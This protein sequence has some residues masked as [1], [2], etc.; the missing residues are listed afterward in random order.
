MKFH[1]NTNKADGRICETKNKGGGTIQRI[2][3]IVLFFIFI[4]TLA[5]SIEV[6]RKFRDKGYTPLMWA[7]F[8]GDIDEVRSIIDGGADL[9]AKNSKGMTALDIA[10]FNRHEEIIK[11]LLKSGGG[12]RSSDGRYIDHGD[13]TITDTNT[14]L[15]WTKEDSYADLGKCLDWNN[16]RRYVNQL[17]T[18][19]YSDWRIP[20]VNEFKAIYE[21]SKKH[22]MG[23]EHKDWRSKYSLGLDS[24]FA[25]GAAYWYWSSETAG[26]CCARIITFDNGFVYKVTQGYCGYGGVRT[27]RR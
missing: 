13:G 20:T 4:A 8:E 1:K 27:V 6:P 14:G 17:N 11:L 5:Y 19:G 16:S 3:V 23:V 9:S 18:G 21:E 7:T 12:T 24:I 25:D 2:F 10:K 22:K 15:M 26:S